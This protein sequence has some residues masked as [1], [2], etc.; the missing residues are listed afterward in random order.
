MKPR[1]EAKEGKKPRKAR[2]QGAK[3]AQEE[4]VNDDISHHRHENYSVFAR[5]KIQ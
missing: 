1:K 3:N 5:E 4:E 2:S